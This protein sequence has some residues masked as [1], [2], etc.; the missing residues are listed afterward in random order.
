M[1]LQAAI[2]MTPPVRICVT[3]SL[4]RST[5]ETLE[6]SAFGVIMYFPSSVM[7]W[8]CGPLWVPTLMAPI[9]VGEAPGVSL[10]TLSSPLMAT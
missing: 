9:A 8:P 2:G 3:C 1:S 10:T 4:A 6:A 5:T 7:W